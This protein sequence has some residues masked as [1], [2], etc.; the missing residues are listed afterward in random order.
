MP[1]RPS[2]TRS[3]LSALAFAA[4]AF[5]AALTATAAGQDCQRCMD[6]Y[7]ACRASGFDHDSCVN[8]LYFCQQVYRCAREEPPQIDP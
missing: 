2:F 3:R 1:L 7:Y 8:D 6:G 5:A 4:F